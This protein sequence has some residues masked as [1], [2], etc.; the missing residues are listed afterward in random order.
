MTYTQ[1]KEVFAAAS[2]LCVAADEELLLPGQLD[3]VILSP[4]ALRRPLSQWESD[5][6]AIEPSSWNWCAI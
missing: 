5:L 2:G 6:F 4:E 1:S 3:L